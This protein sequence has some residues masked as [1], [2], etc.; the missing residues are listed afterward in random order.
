MCAQKK[1]LASV[2]G[3]FKTHTHISRNYAYVCKFDAVGIYSRLFASFTP[4]P[5][6]MNIFRLAALTQKILPKYN[7]GK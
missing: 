7:F 5:S 6:I 3:P 4:L 1:G 2:S